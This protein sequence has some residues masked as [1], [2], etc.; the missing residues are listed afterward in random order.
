[1]LL[2]SDTGIGIGKSVGLG[3]ISFADTLMELK[4]DLIVVLGDRFEIFS[5]VTAA[6]F[7]R[8]PVLH[9]HGGELTAGSL[10][11]SM[12]HA[13]TKM[14]HLHCVATEEYRNRV[15]QLGEHPSRVHCVGGLGVDAIKHTQLLKKSELEISLD[16]RF[17]AKNLLITFHPVTLK[18][19]STGSQMMEELL[20]ALND[21]DETGLIFTLPNAD[22]GG[23]ELIAMVEAFVT[24]HPNARAY[25]SL[26]QARY[27][28]CM[29]LCDGLVGN[30]SSALLE[31]PTFKK[32]AVN[33]GDR[34]LGRMQAENVINCAAERSQIIA[35]L[36]RLY[37]PEFQDGLTSVS[38]PYGDGGASDRVINIIKRINFNELLEKSFY[39]LPIVAPADLIS[40]VS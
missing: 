34:Q 16:F 1:M 29:A 11:E 39:D 20:A 14:A 28:S 31:A 15:I 27:L 23:R 24:K 7:A 18:D 19:S 40:G 33:I 10:D 12:R 26:G 17:K 21:R 6:L 2:S 22:A 13:V 3:V 9:L 30:S 36:E 4:P 38:N 8:I 32:G 5:A 25:S 37:T 35:A